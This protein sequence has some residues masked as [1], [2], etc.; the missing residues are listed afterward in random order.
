[1]KSKA[2][3]YLILFYSLSFSLD[4]NRKGFVAGI[5]IG[6]GIFYWQPTYWIYWPP[7]IVKA[8]FNTNYL[9]NTNFK[10]GYAPGNRFEIQNYYKINVLESESNFISTITAYGFDFSYYFLPV[11]PSFFINMTC[12]FS[13][14]SHP[15]NPNLQVYHGGGS[16]LSIG[17]GREYL[18]HIYALIEFVYTDNFVT[19]GGTVF[20]NSHLKG[21]GDHKN[22]AYGIN[23]VMGILGY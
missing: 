5:E 22:Q 4:G 3:L 8:N 14:W 23:I 15:N 19:G 1:M 6:N 7:E 11:S 16:N 12:G 10:L 9:F 18:K 20:V 21:F 17:F 13:Y 2:I